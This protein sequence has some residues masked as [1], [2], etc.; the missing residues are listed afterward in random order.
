MANSASKTILILIVFI[1]FCSIMV[2]GGKTF[3]TYLFDRKYDVT[4]GSSEIF[5]L[6]SIFNILAPDEIK[7]TNTLTAGALAPSAAGPTATYAL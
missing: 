3:S 7:I 6:T 1:A 4:I 2:S 5:S